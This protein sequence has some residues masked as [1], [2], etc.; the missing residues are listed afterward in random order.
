MNCP[1]PNLDNLTVAWA[2][3]AMAFGVLGFFIGR[4][5]QQDEQP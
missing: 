4:I 5:Y 1:P 3:I 2:V